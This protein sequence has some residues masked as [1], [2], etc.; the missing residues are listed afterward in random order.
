MKLLVALVL[1]LSSS[2]HCLAEDRFVIGW[3]QNE[4]GQSAGLSSASQYSTGTVAIAGKALNDVIAVSAGLNHSLALKSDGTV[5]GWGNNMSGRA[6]GIET[7]SPHRAAGL[8]TFGGEALTNVVAISAGQQSLALRRDGSVISW[9]KDAAGKDMKLPFHLSEVIA[10]SAG[11]NHNLAINRDGKVVSWRS[12]G[13][14]A[15]VDLDDVAAVAACR[16]FY[17]YDLAIT[18]QGS[19]VKFGGRGDVEPQPLGLSNVVAVAAGSSHYLALKKD[20]TVV[21]WG[22]YDVGFGGGP[23]LNDGS[24]ALVRINGVLLSNVMAIAAGRSHSLALKRDG[25]VVGWGTIGLHAA[26]VPAGLSNVVAITAA[27]DFS[28]AITTNA[29]VAERFKH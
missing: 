26:T 23:P 5:V 2:G 14:H 6:I 20:G 4:S 16:S 18:T 22:S 11:G 28:L 13:Y 1:C 19:V 21:E 15:V 9:G 29:A 27:D 3:G 12:E 10:V 8:V 25:S 24:K 7:K 17:G